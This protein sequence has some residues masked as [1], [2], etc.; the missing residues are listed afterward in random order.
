MALNTKDSDRIFIISIT[1]IL[2]SAILAIS[3]PSINNSDHEKELISVSR[4][5]EKMSE[6]PLS[7]D[8][9]FNEI[10]DTSRKQIFLIVNLKTGRYLAILGYISGIVGVIIMISFNIVRL[11]TVADGVVTA[12]ELKNQ[13]KNP[14]DIA[15]ILITLFLTFMVVIITVIYSIFI[16]SEILIL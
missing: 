15:I 6:K 2:L 1:I 5:I 7:K 14:A 10:T 8:L 11:K 9:K 12:D 3:I 13:L 4:H 16:N